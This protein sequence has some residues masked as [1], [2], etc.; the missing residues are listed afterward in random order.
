[1]EEICIA[2]EEHEEDDQKEMSLVVSV[3]DRN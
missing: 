1:M 2:V 3:R